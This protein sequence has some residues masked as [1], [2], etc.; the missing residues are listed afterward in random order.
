MSY[1][2]LNIR[3]LAVP[4]RTIIS[5]FAISV[6]IPIPGASQEA[7]PPLFASSDVLELRIE[8]NFN[9]IHKERK[10]NAKEFPAVLR[11]EGPDGTEQ[12]LELKIRTRGEFRLKKS[13]CRHPPLRLNFPKSKL[14]GTIFEGQDKLK[15]VT[16]C[17][18]RDEFEQNTLEEY[19][20]YR[21]YNVL[22]DSSFR[23]R[24]ARITY[25]DSREEDDDL[26]RYAFVIEDEDAMAK[27]LNGRIVKTSQAP[28]S[29][30]SDEESALVS[31]FQYLIGNTDF[32]IQVFHNIK[33]VRT[34][35]GAYV[36]IPYDFDWAG[37]VEADYAEPNPILGTRTVRD[38]IYRGFCRPAV[39]FPLIYETFQ[40][41]REAIFGL[42]AGQDGLSERAL[43]RD[44]RYIEDFFK[45]LDDPSKAEWEI[46]GTCRA[47]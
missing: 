45:I 42:F 28:A 37:L 19:L 11:M 22:T 34:A 9:K 33:I 30:L 10:K 31:V 20:I 29:Q 47:F 38:R 36:P 27:R 18:D 39:D 5:A 14:E 26:I 13:T 8:A 25:V 24:L 23:V 32:S 16:H 12:E 35:Q 46:V 41:N 40:E 21:M 17:R 3:M 15:L 44:T 1:T 4:S 7:T 6:V 2:V 43:E